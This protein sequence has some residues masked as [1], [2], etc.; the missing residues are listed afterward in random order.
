MVLSFRPLSSRVGTRLA[1]RELQSCAREFVELSPGTRRYRPPAIALPGEIDRITLFNDWTPARD[2]VRYETLEHLSEGE[3]VHAA[4]TAFRV[5]DVLVADGC[6]YAPWAV[7]VVT[8]EKRRPLL[9]GPVDEIDEA[10]LVTTHCGSIFFGDWLMVDVPIELLSLQRGLRPLSI[11]NRVYG[12]E[13]E[14]RERF[15]LGPPTRPSSIVRAASLWIVND[16]GM[17]EGRVKR[18]QTLR[19][20]VR[21]TESD[22]PAR[23]FIDRDGNWGVPRGLANRDE[24]IRA[25]AGRGFEMIHPERMSVDELSKALCCAQICVGVEG[26]ALTHATMMVAPGACIVAIQEADRF[27]SGIKWFADAVDMRYGFL[28]AE[29]QSSDAQIHVDVKR[30]HATLD[31][32]ERAL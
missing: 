10:Q 9:S 24:V 14:Y 27:T 18:Y 13:P 21:S 32:A 8:K 12:H 25:L 5:E 30:L 23:V 26:S 19:N 2:Y 4:T 17:T 16:N 1:K 28:V 15:G 20:R 3:D 6:I 31:L 11:A 29:R 7:S 22:G